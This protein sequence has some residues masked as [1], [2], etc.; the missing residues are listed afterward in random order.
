MARLNAARL[1][2]QPYEHIAHCRLVLQRLS[3]DD[4][5]LTRTMK[6]RRDAIVAKYD[7]DVVTLM[8]QLRG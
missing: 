8:K 4:G 3:P 1:D 5:T 2:Y 7:K 6:P